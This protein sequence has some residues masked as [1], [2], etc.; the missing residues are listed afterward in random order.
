MSLWHLADFHRLDWLLLTAGYMPMKSC[1]KFYQKNSVLRF[2]S[3]LLKVDLHITASQWTLNV[4]A[5][6]DSFAQ[7]LLPTNSRFLLS[8]DRDFCWQTHTHLPWLTIACFGHNALKAW[9]MLMAQNW[10]LA[11]CPKQK[12][13]FF[14]KGQNNFEQFA[15]HFMTILFLCYC[16]AHLFN[17]SFKE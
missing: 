2:M 10:F 8:A 15:L 9:L 17:F 5:L 4:Q 13:E 16:I 3:Q 7:G 14:F 11:L 1:C 12:N 6:F